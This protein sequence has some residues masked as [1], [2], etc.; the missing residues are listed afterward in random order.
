MLTARFGMGLLA[1]NRLAYS[2][3]KCLLCRLTRKPPRSA[4]R[5]DPTPRQLRTGALHRRP[6]ASD[7]ISCLMRRRLPGAARFPRGGKPLHLGEK[8]GKARGE[9]RLI[10][11]SRS[12]AASVGRLAAW[13]VVLSTLTACGSLKLVPIQMARVGQVEVY[14]QTFDFK[15]GPDEPAF[16]APWERDRWLNQR[17]DTELSVLVGPKNWQTLKDLYGLGTMREELVNGDLTIH[18]YLNVVISL[19]PNDV[20]R[21]YIDGS[22]R[23]SL[24]RERTGEILLSGDFYTLSNQFTLEQL[25]RGHIDIDIQQVITRIP[26]HHTYLQKSKVRYRIQIDTQRQAHQVYRIDYGKRH[27]VYLLP[28]DPVMARTD[29]LQRIGFLRFSAAHGEAK[30]LDLRGRGYLRDDYEHLSQ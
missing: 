30:L 28:D 29:E 23:F 8:R 22:G 20:E 27:G 2:F 12:W 14:E 6:P 5:L 11:G 17:I 1:L 16:S 26:G 19:D 25:N 3:K 10:H 13:A 9:G 21:F 7:G 15:K 4:L 18:G 24:V